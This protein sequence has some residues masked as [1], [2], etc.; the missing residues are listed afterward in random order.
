MLSLSR[1]PTP[2]DNGDD[3]QDPVE[4]AEAEELNDEEII[5]IKWVM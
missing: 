5:F 2:A 1:N 4:D 3:D